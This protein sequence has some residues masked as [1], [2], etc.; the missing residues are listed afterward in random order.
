MTKDNPQ[1]GDRFTVFIDRRSS[2]GNLITRHSSSLHVQETATHKPKPGQR[3]QVE[4]DFEVKGS[5]YKLTPLRRK[6]VRPQDTP[7]PRRGNGE[8]PFKKPL[9][10]ANKLIRDTK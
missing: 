1:I 2:S 4:V 3:W 5:I 10:N 9:P 6:K 7:E 8:S